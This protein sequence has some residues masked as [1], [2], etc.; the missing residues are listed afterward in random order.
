[1]W[2]ILVDALLY[3]SP[4]YLFL[5]DGRYFTITTSEMRCVR[6]STIMEVESGN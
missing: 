1:M 3:V 6:V 2:K 5:E 4:V